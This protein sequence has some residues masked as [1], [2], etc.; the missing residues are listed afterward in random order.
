MRL[1]GRLKELSVLAEQTG[2]RFDPKV[3][4]VWLDGQDVC[5]LLNLTKRTL[6]S[7]RNKRILP[8]TSI[9]GKFFYRKSDVTE[10][11]QSKTVKHL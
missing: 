1:L 5:L 3:S 10:Y 7:Y 9:G 4:D 8:Y 11:L 6:Q 2:R